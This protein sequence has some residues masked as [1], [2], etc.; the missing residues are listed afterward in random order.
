MLLFDFPLESLENRPFELVIGSGE[1][2]KRVE[3]DL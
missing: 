2:A 3:L 1:D